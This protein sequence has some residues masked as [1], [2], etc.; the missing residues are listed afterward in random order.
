MSDSS[1]S[2]QDKVK[3]PGLLHANAEP[4]SKSGSKFVINKKT[5]RYSLW[6]GVISGL[7]FSLALWGYEAFL[8]LRAHVAYPWLPLLIGTILCILICTLAALL[9]WLANRALLG[10][11]FWVLAARLIADLA[12]AL[13]LQIVPRLMI[14]L[15]PG[16]Q[17]RLPAYPITDTFRTWAWFGTV[18]L[19]ILFAIVGLLQL[20]LVDSS[21]PAVTAGGRLTAYFI[22]TPVM[23][24]AS[25]M[26][27]NVMNEQLRAPLI[28]TQADLQFAIDHQNVSVD[29]IQ[30]RSM[31]LST[32][33]TIS[34]LF[35]RP[36]R[37]FLGKYDE[38]YSQADVLIDFNGEWIDCNNVSSQPV[39]CQPA[40]NP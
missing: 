36:Y 22:F 27:S 5:F 7:A 40:S 19:G 2:D 23:L 9:T 1:F 6:L 14:F 39:F 10:L 16:L 15:E 29:P 11:V 13:P 38:F 3:L 26:S 20:T 21:V 31:R 32:F 28:A 24:L 25:I 18:W 17:S 35:N 8:L 30:A 4:G 12:I 33:A 37:L 34:S